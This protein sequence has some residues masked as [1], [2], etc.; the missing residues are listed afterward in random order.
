M[1]ILACTL[2][3]TVHERTSIAPL[4]CASRSDLPVT[5]ADDSLVG[6]LRDLEHVWLSKIINSLA[7]IL[8]NPICEDVC[9]S[10]PCFDEIVITVGLIASKQQERA[11]AWTLYP[12]FSSQGIE[13]HNQQS[14]VGCSDHYLRFFLPKRYTLSSANRF[15]SILQ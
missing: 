2:L 5:A 8:L 3:I 12:C 4:L 11:A 10:N 9:V 7:I 1:R 6:I 15:P 14:I 13:E